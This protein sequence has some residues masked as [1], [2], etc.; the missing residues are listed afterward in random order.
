VV[1]YINIHRMEHMSLHCIDDSKYI[2]FIVMMSKLFIV[3]IYGD[4]RPPAARQVLLQGVRRFS[5]DLPEG[6]Y[7]L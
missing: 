1:A 2:L 3:T 7:V 4:S 6:R 5:L